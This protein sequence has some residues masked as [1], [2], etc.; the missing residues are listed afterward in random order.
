MKQ[1]EALTNN[2]PETFRKVKGI[3][4]RKKLLLLLLCVQL[5]TIVV[6]FATCVIAEV[7]LAFYAAACVNFSISVTMW[8]G[9]G[10]QVF[11]KYLLKERIE[12]LRKESVRLWG[13]TKTGNHSQKQTAYELWKRR[14]AAFKEA[15]RIQDGIFEK[16]S[17]A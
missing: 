3:G 7:G 14:D 8:F 2:L 5:I 10:R 16:E 13:I 6:S 12:Y 11:N 15:S 4:T 17:E 1:E 9:F